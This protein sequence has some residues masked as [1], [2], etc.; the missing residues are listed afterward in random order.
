MSKTTKRWI[1]WSVSIGCI[2]LAGVMGYIAAQNAPSALQQQEEAESAA[3]A[4]E[5]TV[6][7]CQVEKIYK[8]TLCEHEQSHEEPIEADWVGLSEEEIEQKLEEG[9]SIKEFSAE[10]VR[11]EKQIAQYCPDHL[12]LQY[13]DGKLLLTQTQAFTDQIKT[14]AAYDIEADTLDL[15]TYDILRAGKVFSSQEEAAEYIR[16]I[17]LRNGE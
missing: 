11:L 7:G 5:R 15:Q 13:S 6:L 9:F 12:L 10:S 14:V 2:L 16:K 3:G 8:Y 17:L 4:G 1:W